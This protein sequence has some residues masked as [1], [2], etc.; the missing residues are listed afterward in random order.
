MKRSLGV[1]A[2]LL[3]V[4]TCAAFSWPFRSSVAMKPKVQ[5]LHP[6]YS[7]SLPDV[8]GQLMCHAATGKCYQVQHGPPLDVK[9]YPIKECSECQKEGGK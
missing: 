2:F 9:D 3:C 1:L 7:V 6:D 5:L 8:S 4:S